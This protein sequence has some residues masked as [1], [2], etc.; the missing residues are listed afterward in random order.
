MNTPDFPSRRCRLA[1]AALVLAGPA[2]LAA[3]GATQV[4]VWH[5]SG[6]AR[7]CSVGEREVITARNEG[8]VAAGLGVAAARARLSA[9]ERELQRGRE[10]LPGEQLRNVGGSRLSPEY[11]LRQARLEDAVAHA[12]AKL[13]AAEWAVAGRG[14]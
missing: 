7:A 14:E 1:L 13:D 5:G 3:A 4:C 9:A 12:Q 11:F 2:A 6:E 10:P 8:A